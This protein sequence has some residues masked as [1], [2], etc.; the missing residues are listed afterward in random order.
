MCCATDLVTIFFS[1]SLVHVSTAYSNPYLRNVDEQVYGSTKAEDHQMFINGV[2]VLP[3]E[4]IGTIADRFQKHH[5]NTYTLT[6]QMA[7]Q[8]VVEYHD[9]LPLCIVRPS[10]VTAS[11]N[12]PYP[13]WIDNVYGITGMRCIVN[14]ENS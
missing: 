2:G 12:E 10:I 14:F 4:F 9:R 1:Q 5:P 11:I 6:K 8:I 7:E 3:D 13:G